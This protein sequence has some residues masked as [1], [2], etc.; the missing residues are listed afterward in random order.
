MAAK[1][2]KEYIKEYI[3]DL[4]QRAKEDYKRLLLNIRDD[5][6][7]SGDTDA[8][9]RF[10][11]LVADREYEKAFR[12]VYDYN[13][14]G[15]S[16]SEEQGNFCAYFWYIVAKENNYDIPEAIK[17]LQH[18]A[19]SNRYYYSSS[20]TPEGKLMTFMLNGQEEVTFIQEIEKYRP[21]ICTHKLSNAKSDN[22]GWGDRVE[23]DILGLEYSGERLTEHS[24]PQ[25]KELLMLSGDVKQIA[26]ARTGD[27]RIK[28]IDLS[29]CK[30]AVVVT[31]S[32][33]CSATDEVIL[34]EVPKVQIL[35]QDAQNLEATIKRKTGVALAASK[36]IASVIKEH[37]VTVD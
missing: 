8:F 31:P 21:Y 4:F 22:L 36:G 2:I 26:I 9:N 23:C 12:L 10:K 27:E 7:N 37:L 15:Y 19:G 17:A 13:Q 28:V 24:L 32:T 11:D 35:G 14:S 29:Q 25:V 5:V 33:L 1:N 3:S 20:V 30:Q 16:E 34:P 6:K 18:A